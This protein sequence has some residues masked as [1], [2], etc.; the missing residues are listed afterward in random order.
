MLL[1]VI[2][3]LLTAL[4]VGVFAAPRAR[5]I[6]L[7][8]ARRTGLRRALQE[9]AASLGAE[10]SGD[11]FSAVVGGVP[12]TV[13]IVR[14]FAQPLAVEIA[15]SLEDLAREPAES[16]GGYRSS[17]TLRVPGRPRVRVHRSTRLSRLG[18]RLGILRKLGSSDPAFDASFWVESD[19][20]PED[21][22]KV[23]S[24]P[25][26]R[27]AILRLRDEGVDTALVNEEGSSLAARLI[28]VKEGQIN[29]FTLGEVTEALASAA[30]ALPVFEGASGRPRRGIAIRLLWGITLAA[31]ITAPILPWVAS[32]LWPPIE[33]LDH[34]LS[35]Q[36]FTVGAAIGLGL[37]APVVALVARLLRARPGFG[38]HLFGIAVALFPALPAHG[39]F[40]VSA[41]NSLL[42][43][44]AVER[45]GFVSVGT[46]TLDP[47]FRRYHVAADWWEQER[48][49]SPRQVGLEAPAYF[50][51]VAAQCP[52]RAILTTGNGLFGLD[53]VRDVRCAPPEAQI[54][55]D[56]LP[57]G[58]L[59]KLRQ[60]RPR[61]EGSGKVLFRF[62]DSEQATRPFKQVYV[63]MRL[64]NEADEPRWFV[65]P[66]NLATK[67]EA[68]GG[69]V[70]YVNGS[71]LRGDR[72]AVLVQVSGHAESA[73]QAVLLGPRADVSIFGFKI[74]S[75]P[76]PLPAA[77][78]ID[79]IIARKVTLGEEPLEAWLR[80]DPIVNGSVMVVDGRSTGSSPVVYGKAGVNQRL[81]VIQEEE[82]IHRLIE[83]E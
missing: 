66:L 58:A 4:F 51:A 54:P 31:A 24:D 44:S 47:T 7:S 53:W 71:E 15:A 12:V 67:R 34:R 35:P 29:V 45:V 21:T 37:W 61:P 42:D 33:P 5:A 20:S 76:S 52:K 82:R 70:T 41:L 74:E 6:L 77:L 78:S 63:D 39:A 26:V 64:R 72:S 1:L 28:H 40:L 69:P 43:A 16:A 81:L 23:L 65:L 48:P 3:L 13:R 79:V 36:I 62:V 50:H 10:C 14:P 38:P 59:A 55:L 11:A 19:A 9:A 80:P 49:D 2:P 57:V 75:W 25:R 30:R 8:R 56:D 68:P 17:P 32:E 73:C 18:E 27:G 46:S 60:V 22:A 83:T